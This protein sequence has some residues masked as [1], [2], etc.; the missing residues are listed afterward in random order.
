MREKP[1]YMAFLKQS[2][3]LAIFDCASNP[4]LDT[5]RLNIEFTKKLTYSGWYREF[6]RLVDGA[7]LHGSNSLEVVFDVSKPGHVGFEH[8][9]FD[10]L[11]FN[12]KCENIQNDEFLLRKYEVSVMRL[13]NFRDNFGFDPEQ[14]DILTNKDTTKD[15]RDKTFCI[16]KKYCKY[17]SIVYVA[18]YCNNSGITNWLKAPEPLKMGVKQKTTT[19]QVN[20]MTGMPE[21]VEQ[22]E[23]IPIDMYPIFNLIYRDDEQETIIDH[24]GRAF[25]DGP[26][27]EAHTSV[28]TGYVNNLLRSAN[29]YAS[30]KQLGDDNSGDIKQLDVQLENGAIYNSPMEFWQLPAPDPS[31]LGSLNYLNTMNA[32]NTGKAN[33]ASMNRKDTRKTAKEM[34]MAEDETSRISSTQLASFSEFVR[35]VFKFSWVIIQSQALNEQ[36]QFL[37]IPQ[38]QMTDVNGQ[39]VSSGQTIYVNDIATISQ[40]YEIRPAGDSDVVERAEKLANMQQDWPVV[41]NTPLKDVFLLDY[42]SLRY[43][44]KASDYRRVYE[45][46]DVGKKLV[47]SLSTLLQAAISPQE[48]AQMDPRQ[49]QMLQQQVQQY[50]TPAQAP[51]QAA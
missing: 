20:P 11:F 17:N 19:Q 2:H 15:A 49:L 33:F 10:K 51:A 44:N 16:Y 13:E 29:V 34:D 3:R 35:E 21:P 28:L 46:G 23:D 26:Q 45:Q 14:V 18:W 30:P 6:E 12:K 25:L 22:M 50:L 42:L 32:Q 40:S 31:T 7:A 37:L 48:A 41:Q 1:D 9:G 43:P 5:E 36:I 24:K 47:M 4:E 39:Q 38:E 8:V 27:Q